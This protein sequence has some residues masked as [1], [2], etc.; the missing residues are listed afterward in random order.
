M[1]GD[2]RSI[3]R[4]NNSILVMPNVV[5]A[6]EKEGYIIGYR[7][8]AVPKAELPFGIEDQSYG[9]FIYFKSGNRLNV[10]LSKA[11]LMSYFEKYKLDID[12]DF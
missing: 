3:V 6:I 9:Y 4:P 11:E 7:E 12:L 8:V 5:N 2:A 1:Y 10:G